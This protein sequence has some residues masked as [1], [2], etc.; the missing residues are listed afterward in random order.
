[1]HTL[2]K[3]FIV[4]QA[5]LSAFILA[6]VVPLAVN[7]DTWKDKY[8]E[9][10]SSVDSLGSTLAAVT[11]KDQGTAIQESLKYQNAQYEI[12]GLRSD[13]SKK[14][15]T[16][17]DLRAQI[18]SAQLDAAE[19]R[20]QLD[21]LTASQKTMSEIIEK[22]GV[23]I[24]DRRNN[25]LK[26]QRNSIELQDN[27]LEREARLE[28]A[29]AAIEILQEQLYAALEGPAPTGGDDTSMANSVASP[30][31][32]GRILEVEN[33]VAGNKFAVIDMGSRDGLSSN[34]RF[35][36]SRD[37]HFVGYLVLTNVDINRS[38]GRIELEQSDGVESGDDVLGGVQ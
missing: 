12:A 32:K 15:Q 17:I 27:L 8:I 20:A 5:L 6:L 21:T 33:D 3:I 10:K 31:V 37:R 22:Q 38:S 16:L 11:M 28:V 26:I 13:L 9:V 1:M 19:V 7:Q 23:E 35:L 24:T 34:M 25:S 29:I 14:D 2:T 30:P 18:G 36:I 4:L